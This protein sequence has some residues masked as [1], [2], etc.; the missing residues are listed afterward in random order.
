MNLTKHT[1]TKLTNHKVPAAKR[2]TMKNVMLLDGGD[3]AFVDESV[4]VK[5]FIGD[6][7]KLMLKCVDARR[8]LST[9]SRL[10]LVPASPLQRGT[11]HFMLAVWK[12]GLGA[13][14]SSQ[15]RV[16]AS[17]VSSAK[18]LGK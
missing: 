18:L 7:Q 13:A 16:P 5:P 4:K 6:D 1:G 9:V 12:A 11:K 17:S 2:I 3:G 8:L 14:L 10:G 15:E